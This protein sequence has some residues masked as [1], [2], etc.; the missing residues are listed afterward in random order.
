MNLK[1]LVATQYFTRKHTDLE[2]FYSVQ[3]IRA[4]PTLVYVRLVY[5]VVILIKLSI[6]TSTTKLGEALKPEDIKVSLYLEKLLVHL[7]AVAM[8]DNREIHTL[9]AK[10][11]QIL[12]KLKFWFQQQGQM[13][14]PTHDETWPVVNSE[15]SEPT[16]SKEEDPLK[17][18]DKAKF[19]TNFGAAPTMNTTAWPD[20]LQSSQGYSDPKYSVQPSWDM[21]APFDFPMDLDPDLLAHLIQDDQNLNYLDN[22]TLDLEAFNQMDYLNNMPDFGSWPMQ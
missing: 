12:I 3:Q 17:Y 18:T 21:N 5:A 4:T 22:G 6:S 2:A 9:G 16:E 10:F 15:P 19:V 11:L 20:H 13:N 1:E 8:L 14:R 7:K